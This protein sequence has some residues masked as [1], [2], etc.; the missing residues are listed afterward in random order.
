[1]AGATR[2]ADAAD[3]VLIV[4]KADADLM[5]KSGRA[6]EP[7]PCFVCFCS[8]DL[9]EENFIQGCNTMWP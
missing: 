8:S 9:D 6:N 5:P 2:Q 4:A 3:L 1:M 7:P